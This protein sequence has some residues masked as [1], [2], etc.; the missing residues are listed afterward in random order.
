MGGALGGGRWAPP[1]RGRV[2]RW[3]V[4]DVSRNLAA[5]ARGTGDAHLIAR[6][7]FRCAGA[8][9]GGRQSRGGQEG[10]EKR[11]PAGRAPRAEEG[12]KARGRA[13]GGGPPGSRWA[14]AGGRWPVGVGPPRGS[15]WAVGGGRWP[16]AGGRWAVGD[17]SALPPG[18]LQRNRPA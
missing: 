11:E 18:R 2:G 3:P 16:V 6:K 4:G 8:P 17:V 9:G 15:R 12:R 10:G 1:P 13:V 5:A 7:H 14:A